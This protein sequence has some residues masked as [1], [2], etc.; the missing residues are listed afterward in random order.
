MPR[1]ICDVLAV[2]CTP[3]SAILSA[4][5][6]AAPLK[7][8]SP[9]RQLPVAVISSFAISSYGLLYLSV[10]LRYCCI[11]SRSTSDRRSVP[12]VRPMRMFVQIV[13]QFRTYSSLYSSPSSRSTSCRPLVALA[14]GQIRG[15]LLDRRHAANQV[16]IHAAAPLAVGRR[17]RRHQVVIAPTLANRVVDQRNFRHN[18][19]RRPSSHACGLAGRLTA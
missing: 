16:E 9:G 12:P 6:F 7:S 8:S 2:A 10:S 4:R 17:L 18:R 5:K 15:Q 13:V 11:P 19:S 3:S 1:K 14:V